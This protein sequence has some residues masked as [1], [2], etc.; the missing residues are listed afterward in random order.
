MEIAELLRKIRRLEIRT[1]RL[2]DAGFGGAYRSLFKGQGMEFSEVRE[3][4]PGDDVRLIDWNVSSRHSSLYVK[5]MIEERELNV[6]VAVD[7]SASHRFGAR[8]AWKCD[9]AAELCGLL[10]FSAVQNGDRVGLLTFTDAIER[11]IPSKRGRNHA[12][13]LVRDLLYYNP[14]GVGT[15]LSA[16][17][18]FLHRTIKR[19]SIVFFVSDFLTDEDF[20]RPLAVVSRRHEVIAVMVRDVRE[21][22]MPAMGYV[23]FEDAETGRTYIVNTSSNRFQEHYKRRQAERAARL[24]ELFKKT[25]VDALEVRTDIPYGVTLNKFFAERSLR[26]KT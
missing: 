4:A 19:R 16:A 1:C 3:Y 15:N 10:A 11:Y 7:I 2:V 14:N 24:R 13:R 25:R 18:E 9:I 6:I 26:S 17:L 23:E 5:K 12:L 22:V 20:S 21:S 8:N